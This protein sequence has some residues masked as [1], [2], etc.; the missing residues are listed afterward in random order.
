MT[1]HLVPDW[2]SIHTIVFDFDGVFTDNMVSVDQE[3]RESVSCHRG[4]GLAFDLLRRFASLHNWTVNYFILSKETNPVVSARARKL[5]V[6]CIQGVEDKASYLRSYVSSH[7]P[8]DRSSFS[9]LVY[10]GN[11]LND[12]SPMLLSGFSFAPSDAHPIVQRHASLVLPQ[13]GG[14][15]FVRAAIEQILMIERLDIESIV[16]LL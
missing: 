16:N 10:L 12:L 14:R 5:K 7:F 13:K 11:D 2:R 9:G 6:E 15:G 8:D 4:D 1:R 3:G